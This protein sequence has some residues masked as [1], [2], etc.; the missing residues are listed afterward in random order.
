MHMGYVLK[1]ETAENLLEISLLRVVV[2]TVKKFFKIS[3][4]HTV[5]CGPV[6]LRG[7]TADIF[8]MGELDEGK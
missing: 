5:A 8:L 3:V 6:S 4:V 1:D 2:A 7:S